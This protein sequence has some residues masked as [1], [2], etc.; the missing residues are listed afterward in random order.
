MARSLLMR[1]AEGAAAGVLFLL[2]VTFFA[3]V[4]GGDTLIWL[5]VF[6]PAVFIATGLIWYLT[7]ADMPFAQKVLRLFLYL[8]F[9]ALTAIVTFKYDRELSDVMLKTAVFPL[10]G[11]AMIA[12]I[13]PASPRI[14]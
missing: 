10:L 14:D 9:C 2:V 7:Q 6:W 12:A 5:Y 8:V 13:F 1:H 4:L 3:A 11:L